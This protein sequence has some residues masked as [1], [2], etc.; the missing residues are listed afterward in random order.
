MSKQTVMVALTHTEIHVLQLAIKFA[1]GTIIAAPA[2]ECVE[3]LFLFAHEGMRDDSAKNL[4]D[5]LIEAHKVAREVDPDERESEGPT[6]PVEP[7]E[8][9][10]FL[11]SLPTKLFKR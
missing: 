9:D 8:K 4:A 10:P 3:N 7:E 6:E 2:E 11:T 5:K 1:A